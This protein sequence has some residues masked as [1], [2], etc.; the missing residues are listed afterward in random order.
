MHR[1]WVM[2]VA[3]FAATSTN[4]VVATANAAP[5]PRVTIQR[6]AVGVPHITARSYRDLGAGVGYAYAQDNVCTLANE[7]VTVRARRSLT[8]G[9]D[10]GTI[11]SA[12][13]ADR[14]VDSD[15]FWQQ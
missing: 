8:F 3:V 12:R 15:L 5:P 9:P 14:N 7:L 2:V 11:A 6:D 13:V 1:V 4:V 10:G